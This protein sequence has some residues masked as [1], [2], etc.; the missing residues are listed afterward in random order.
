MTEKRELTVVKI[1]AQGF[2][3][4]CNRMKQLEEE[5][6]SLKIDN[7]FLQRQNKSLKLRCSD[8][9]IKLSKLETE[10]NDLKFTRKYLTSE[11]A[12]KQFA[13]DLLGGA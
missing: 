1:E 12:G 13:Q 2:T 10:I 8:Y 3:D 6:Q 11:E 5:N 4:L 7:D 9:S